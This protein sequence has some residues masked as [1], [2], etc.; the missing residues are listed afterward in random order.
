MASPEQERR[1]RAR[2][3]FNDRLLIDIEDARKTVERA[4]ANRDALIRQAVAARI[5][6]RD[7]M[8]SAGLSRTRIYQ[9]AADPGTE[10]T[11]P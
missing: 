5:P 3:E 9:I 11:T 4:V 6:R 2:A 7:I 1:A 10:G 8:A